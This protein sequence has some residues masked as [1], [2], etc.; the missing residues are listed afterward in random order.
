[1]STTTYQRRVLPPSNV[2]PSSLSIEELLAK[3]ENQLAAVVFT[4]GVLSN[5]LRERG[6]SNGHA[7]AIPRRRHA[8]VAQPTAPVAPHAQPVVKQRRQGAASRIV[9]AVLSSTGVLANQLH[10]IAGY[11]VGPSILNRLSNTHDFTW[12]AKGEGNNLRYIGNRKVRH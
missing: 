3:A 5:K 9:A 7:M 1:M 11:K 8:P 4:I 2:L 6:Q 12:W 10:E